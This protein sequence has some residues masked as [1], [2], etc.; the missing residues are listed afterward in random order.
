MQFGSVG[1]MSTLL[2]LTSYSSPMAT[3]CY[4][5]G[6]A[7]SPVVGALIVQLHDTFGFGGNVFYLV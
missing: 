6:T 1:A 3:R 7:A 5:F 2:S 4:Q